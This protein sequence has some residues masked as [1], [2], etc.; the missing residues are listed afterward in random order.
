MLPALL[1][2][3]AT[4]GGSIAGCSTVELGPPPEGSGEAEPTPAEVAPSPEALPS[5]PAVITPATDV[6]ASLF[7]SCALAGGRVYCWG[8]RIDADIGAE[9][10]ALRPPFR[11]GRNENVRRI[12]ANRRSLCVAFEPGYVGCQDFGPR[13]G[14]P[15]IGYNRVSD[16]EEF[17][18][19]GHHNCGLNNGLVRCAGSNQERQRGL[20]D[21]YYPPR[22][23]TVDGLEGV[24]EV[25]V[26]LNFT[27]ARSGGEVKCFGANY[28]GQL[29]DGGE[30]PHWRPEPVTG[31]TDAVDIDAHYA[32][33]LACAVHGNDTVS[34]WGSFG[35]GRLGVDRKPVG[36][37]PVTLPH[38]SDA[39]LAGLRSV[40]VGIFEVCA[41]DGEGAVHCWRESLESARG[42]AGAAVFGLPEQVPGLAGVVEVAMGMTHSCARTE[43]GQIGCWGMNNYGQLGDGT[44]ETQ[45]LV[46]VEL[47]GD[48]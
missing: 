11:V 37:E 26:G 34:C 25:A 45:A 40:A 9:S 2:I 1:A 6:T 14:T 46:W 33:T 12:R 10:V 30:D 13:V 24:E 20:A 36:T 19:G 39:P 48:S 27:C 41:V 16:F 47:P 42:Q 18:V 35:V 32:G 17:V 31:L 8:S 21:R 4:A 23:N 29:G 43:A 28:D 44:T 22:S 38:D 7:S 3:G 5:P 15:P